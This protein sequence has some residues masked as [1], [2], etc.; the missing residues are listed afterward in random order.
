MLY[1]VELSSYLNFLPVR[2]HWIKLLCLLISA[3][4]ANENGGLDWDAKLLQGKQVLCI[5][6]YPWTVEFKLKLEYLRNYPSWSSILLFLGRGK[7]LSHKAPQICHSTQ[8][9]TKGSEAAGWLTDQNV[10]LR[11]P[12]GMQRSTLWTQLL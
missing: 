9:T 5:L 2:H 11:R 7:S 1:S 10:H 3:T 6:T 4:L 8:H 12:A